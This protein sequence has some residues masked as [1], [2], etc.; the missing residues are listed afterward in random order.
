MADAGDN[1]KTA[2]ISELTAC[3]QTIWRCIS[4]KNFTGTFAGPRFA[5]PHLML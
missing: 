5:T 1:S 4:T 3:W 2:L